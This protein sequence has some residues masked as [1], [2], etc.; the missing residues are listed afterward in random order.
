MRGDEAVQWI[1]NQ[2]EIHGD[3]FV[4]NYEHNGVVE[5]RVNDTLVFGFNG[6]FVQEFD[7]PHI[8]G[9]YEGV[10]RGEATPNDHMWHNE[11]PPL[12]RDQWENPA[13]LDGAWHNGDEYAR[14]VLPKP[15]VD[16]NGRVFFVDSVDVIEGDLKDVW[17]PKIKSLK[18]REDKMAEGWIQGGY[19]VTTSPSTGNSVP[20]SYMYDERGQLI[21]TTS[22]RVVLCKAKKH[23]VSEGVEF[24]EKCCWNCQTGDAPF[25]ASCRKTM[26]AEEK[27]GESVR[28]FAS[29]HFP[30]LV[31]FLD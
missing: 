16:P 18:D 23:Y 9:L 4:V 14:Q 1:R 17:E 11:L 29:E 22:I 6:H 19:T 5:V 31:P 27:E 3:D 28:S 25:C 20:M 2:C 8:A 30:S 24:C 15:E 12:R 10:R 13:L 7:G 21:G 26:R